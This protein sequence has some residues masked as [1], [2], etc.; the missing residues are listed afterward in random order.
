MNARAPMLQ[1]SRGDHSLVII[2]GVGREEGGGSISVLLDT[3]QT[4]K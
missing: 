1:I 3:V 4:N 2:R